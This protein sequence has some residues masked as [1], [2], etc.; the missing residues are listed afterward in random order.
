MAEEEI[1]QKSKNK[2][3]NVYL[4]LL[5]PAIISLAI[6]ITSI[7]YQFGQKIFDLNNTCY[8]I[9]VSAETNETDEAKDAEVFKKI[10][11]ILA[12]NKLNG[13][14]I[15]KNDLGGHILADKTI[16]QEKSYQIILM[17]V[18]RVKA[19]YIAEEIRKAMKQKLVLVE[20]TVINKSFVA[21]GRKY[22]SINDVPAE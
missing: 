20:E 8:Y 4:L 18:S 5:L 2:K 7:M 21:D 3:I 17:D 6:S 10:G 22:S 12:E 13:F 15:L 11:D 14:T 19:Y 9:F 16:V 1:I